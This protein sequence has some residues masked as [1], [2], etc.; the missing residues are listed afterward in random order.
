[1][2]LS[3]ILLWLVWLIGCLVSTW[4][5]ITLVS[6]RFAILPQLVFS[7][8]TARYCLMIVLVKGVPT[9]YWYDMCGC[10]T[11]AISI[12]SLSS[13]LCGSIETILFAIPLMVKCWWC[14]VVD[15]STIHGV[16][17]TTCVAGAWAG[18]H[19]NGSKFRLMIIELGTSIA[20]NDTYSLQETR[21]LGC[22]TQ[23][24][25]YESMTFCSDPC[26]LIELLKIGSVLDVGSFWIFH[27]P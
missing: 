1:M 6:R 3:P 26:Y 10:V 24:L 27:N 12:Y 22:L 16:V 8:L 20:C 15:L 4:P 21:R 5:E 9:E 14:V 23:F 2:S 19:G 25:R 7:T 18:E 17:S 13:V 11:V